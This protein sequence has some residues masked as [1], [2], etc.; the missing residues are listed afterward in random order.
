MLQDEG[1]SV[2]YEDI[3]IVVE[4][5]LGRNIEDVFTKFEKQP[6]AAASLAQVHKAV[7]KENNQEVAV[8]I[9]F[10]TLKLQTKYDMM[11]AS[12]WISLTDR[13]AK[14]LNFR[15]INLYK[16]YSDFQ[17]SRLVELDFDLELENGV[18]TTNN[19]K[20]DDRIYIPKFYKKY[21]NDR[22]ITMEYIGNAK[23]IDDVEGIN[24]KYGT[25][26]TT[27]YVCQG[28]M[29]IFAKQ[30]FLYGLVHS[31]GH[32]G[33]ILVRDH[34]QHKHRPQ[35]V[36][37][38]HGHY[39]EVSDS[40]RL[41]F[42]HLWYYLCTF[43][44]REVK[45]IAAEF[46]MAEHYRYLPLIFTYRTLNS[47]KSLGTKMTNEEIKMLKTNDDLNME[48]IGFLLQKLPWDIILIF[49][50]THLITIHNKK[51]GASDRT[52]FMRFNHYCLKALAGTDS[53]LSYWTLK[54]TLYFKILLFEYCFPVFKLFFGTPDSHSVDA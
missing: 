25:E 37:L 33:N 29:D 35:I 49:K 21:S 52:K 13:V 47:R 45:R 24:K 7:L 42:C 3:K 15:G 5:D 26:N 16:L 51:L 44:Y 31:D 40:F 20:D 8:K 32:P 28:L 10:P 36:L 27:K 23:R 4:N 53:R 30:I 41:K 12:F 18:K 39:C 19:F 54:F 22:M 1:P 14:Y 9:Q 50:A 6:I 43:N 48:N 2:S 46:G 11:V 38:D 17:E 34:P